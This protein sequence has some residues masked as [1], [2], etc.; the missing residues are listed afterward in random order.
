M[1]TLSFFLPPFPTFIKGG[2]ACPQVGHK[3]F[4]RTFHIFDLIYVTKGTMYM[5]E[6]KV[7]YEVQEGEY[8]ILVPGRE[9]YGYKPCSEETQFYWI[10]FQIDDDKYQ[11]VEESMV[12]WS[13]IFVEDN[14][15][16]KPALFHFHIP[17]YGKIKHRDL[18]EGTL[19]RLIEVNGSQSPEQKLRQQMLFQDFLLIL[20]KEAFTIPTFAEQVTEKVVTYIHQ[21]YQESIQMSDLSQ[22]LLFHP[23]YLTRCMKFVTGMSPI[24][25]LH[26]YRLG[27]AKHLLATTHDKVSSIAKSVGIMDSTYFSKLFKKEEG[28]TPIEYRRVANRIDL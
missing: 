17:C 18:I 7:P 19:N 5:M 14:T 16:T 28:I 10:H 1:G 6:A 15:F 22:A 8:L 27:V 2:F 26:H 25:Y 4:R 11:M 12:D 21:H 20:Q 9:H 3:H 24:Q 23:D 13:T